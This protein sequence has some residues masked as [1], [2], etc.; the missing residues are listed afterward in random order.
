MASVLSLRCP[1]CGSTLEWRHLSS[2]F[3]CPSCKAKLRSNH[4]NVAIWTA[5]LLPLP[6]GLAFEFGAVWV[7]IA[8]AVSLALYFPVVKSFTTVEQADH[9]HAT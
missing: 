4:N 5:L 7:A 9:D 1:K 6:F 8:V 2:D 3:S